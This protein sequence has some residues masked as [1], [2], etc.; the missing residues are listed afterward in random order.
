[1]AL[2]HYLTSGASSRAH[3]AFLRRLEGTGTLQEADRVVEE[4]VGRCREVLLKEVSCCSGSS[5]L[6]GGC[7]LLSACP[8]WKG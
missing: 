3:Y 8:V 6:W 2:P 7:W 4:E 5:G 1:M